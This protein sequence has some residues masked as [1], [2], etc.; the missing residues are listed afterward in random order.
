MM[1]VDLN[2]N[3]QVIEV[4]GNNMGRKITQLKMDCAVEKE[5]ITCG[6]ANFRLIIK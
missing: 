2:G 4:D 3:V 6:Y 5:T 1:T